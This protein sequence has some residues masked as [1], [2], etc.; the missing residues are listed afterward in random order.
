V[1]PGATLAR[2]VTRIALEA[3]WARFAPGTVALEPGFQFEQV[4]TYF[5]HGPRSLRVRY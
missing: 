4:S 2:V 3:F 1:C 5:E